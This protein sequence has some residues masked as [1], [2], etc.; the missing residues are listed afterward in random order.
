MARRPSWPARTR[1]AEGVETVQAI[2]ER[3]PHWFNAHYKRLGMSPQKLPFDQHA[4]VGLCAPRPVLLAYAEADVWA[5]PA[6]AFET[7]RQADPVYRLLCDEGFDG[8][9][10]PAPDA[11]IDSRLGYA[12]RRGGHNMGPEDWFTFLRFADKWL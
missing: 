6:G 5:N 9:A 1:D 4:M 2:N 3:F 11:L 8:Q 10:L 12:L 7:A